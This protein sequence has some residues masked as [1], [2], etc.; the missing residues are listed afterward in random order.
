MRV[1]SIWV[2]TVSRP[3]KRI[4]ATIYMSPGRHG[5]NMREKYWERGQNCPAA[6]AIGMEPILYASSHSDVPKGISEY[7]YTG[8]F[9]KR[10]V[11]VTRGVTTD[12]FIPATAEIVLEGEMIRDQTVS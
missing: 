8:G 9:R 4:V 10:P 12:L 3:T 11:E 5:K 6:V 7:D 2:T 1:G